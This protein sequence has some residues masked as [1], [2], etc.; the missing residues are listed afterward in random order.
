KE[1]LDE[2]FGCLMAIV[3]RVLAKNQTASQQKREAL[4][5]FFSCQIKMV[6]K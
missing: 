3:A 5:L 6:D 4:N 1:H 2:P